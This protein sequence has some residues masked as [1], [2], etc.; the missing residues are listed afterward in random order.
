M[1]QTFAKYRT[2]HM[3]TLIIALGFLPPTV[4]QSVYN[5]STVA[6]LIS[7]TSLA[8]NDD[9]IYVA[10]GT[11]TITA[12]SCTA[13]LTLKTS[14][15][16][17]GSDTTPTIFEHNGQGRLFNIKNTTGT[18]YIKNIVMIA[19]STCYGGGGVI[20][21]DGSTTKLVIDHCDITGTIANQGGAVMVSNNAFVEIINSKIHDCG[22][23]SGGA[24]FVYY[25]TLH[26]KNS[27]VYNNQINDI[28]TLSYEHGGAFY[29]YAGIV[30]I[31]DSEIFDN[32]AV[33][34]NGTGGAIYLSGGS[35]LELV[36][37]TISNNTSQNGGGAIFLDGINTLNMDY[38]TVAGN[39][40]IGNQSGVSGIAYGTSAKIDIT[41]SIITANTGPSGG[42]LPATGAKP[43]E[44]TIVGADL[45]V[46]STTTLPN[47]IIPENDVILVDSGYVI[48]IISLTIED[49]NGITIA[50]PIPKYED[51]SFA[52]GAGRRVFQRKVEL[53]VS[54]SIVCASRGVV[55]TVK[56]TYFNGDLTYNLYKQDTLKIFVATKNSDSG[57]AI[58]DSVLLDAGVDRYVAEMLHIKENIVVK[59]IT[60]NEVRLAIVPDNILRKIVH[61][62][63]TTPD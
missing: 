44:N 49:Q 11:Y 42:D 8:R 40:T 4:A 28:P 3:F 27:K 34:G 7:A 50:V 59:R 31:E 9:T 19:N 63:N 18:V 2:K 23:I 17:I 43:K 37:T 55:F 10:G 46:N 32:S 38:C 35:K 62:K 24:F 12:S 33:L 5:V 26:I 56:V 1:L 41:N 48:T 61:T 16:L 36:H 60:S 22:S 53:R 51:G 58:F 15:I 52:I 39:S 54:D 21:A 14:A 13:G 20:F 6:Q 30:K 47:L 29:I 25:A 45:I 57:V